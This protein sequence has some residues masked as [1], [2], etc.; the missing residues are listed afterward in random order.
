LIIKYPII[1]EKSLL[2]F[3]VILAQKSPRLGFLFF[4]TNL[5]CSNPLFAQSGPPPGV[6]G[7]NN[8]TTNNGLEGL[9]P[10]DVD[11][12]K[13]FYFKLENPSQIIPY[14]DTLLNN[15]FHQYELTR[16]RALDHWN[17][18]N[19]G[20]A[21]MPVLYETKQHKGFDE[22]F[23]QFDLY[24][25]ESN[26]LP[27]YKIQ[28]PITYFYYS[29]NAQADAQLE[30]RFSTN[31]KDGI[32]ISL[33]FSRIDNISLPTRQVLGYTYSVPSARTT[34]FALGLWFHGKENGYDGYLTFTNNVSSQYDNGGISTDSLFQNSPSDIFFLLPVNLKTAATRHE[35]REYAYTQYYQLNKKSPQIDTTNI[36]KIIPTDSRKYL[37]GLKTGYTTSIYKFYQTAPFISADST[38]YN[39]FIT[40]TR[41]LRYYLETY[42]FENTFSI[43]TTKSRKVISS[44]PDSI[45]PK[46]LKTNDWLELNLTHQYIK[47]DQEP[48]SDTRGNLIAGAKWNFTPNDQIKIESNAHFNLLGSNLGDYRLNANAFFQAKGLGSM[49][50]SFTN[51]LYS[52]SYIQQ[53][54]YIT[55]QL[56][57]DNNWTKTLE[58]NLS[59]TLKIDKTQTGITGAYTLLN[60]YIYFDALG[61]PR[62]E[63]GAISLLQLV[64]NQDLKYKDLHLDNTIILQK[65]T[66]ENIIQVPN[67]YSKHSLYVEGDIFKKNMLLRFGFDMRYHSAWYANSYMP[68]IGQFIIQQKQEIPAFPLLDIFVS[69]KVSDFRFFFKMDN[70]N[71]FWQKQPAY[72]LY[73]YPVPDRLI[74]FG[75]GWN[76]RN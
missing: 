1:L 11:T 53:Q 40:D 19:N 14:K 55:S 67:I 34:N 72:T 36:K 76:F 60:N 15:N 13:V 50:V 59:A 63:T 62:Q 66:S 43:S 28:T 74:K 49:K 21:T 58:T 56:L 17:L 42:K 6:G 37:L 71:G 27:F 38:Y 25:I 39:D 33:D 16:R 54:T 18:G 51:Q 7:G 30:A 2:K 52:A 9:E 48:I 35:I 64:I 73:H 24:K 57:W 41:G 70:L 29:G 22:G 68:I 47:L 32:N 8:G 26:Q 44:L 61:K 23:H 3:G 65:S 75:L 10:N 4:L 69:F 46:E 12:S 45:A 20:T 5:L 31:F